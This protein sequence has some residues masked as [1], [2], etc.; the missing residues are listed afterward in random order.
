MKLTQLCKVLAVALL[1]VACTK[2]K[3][4]SPDTNS[5]TTPDLNKSIAYLQGM[6]D[7]KE[8]LMHTTMDLANAKFGIEVDESSHVDKDGG[9]YQA[10]YSFGCVLFDINPGN[11]EEFEIRREVKSLQPSDKIA[12]TY[13]EF[14][15]FFSIGKHAFIDLEAADGFLVTYNAE[16]A[17]EF[18]SYSTKVGAVSVEDFIDI[19]S[20]I[21]TT[22]LGENALEVKGILSANLYDEDGTVKMKLKDVKFKY[23]F[24]SSDVIR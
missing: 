21:S 20:V 17:N 22:Y 1:S 18:V 16:I 19:Q 4:V 8:K 12:L 10:Y 15:G 3:E 2:K 9:M 6:V 14:K 7:G 5:T 23:I 13:D 24:T 11:D